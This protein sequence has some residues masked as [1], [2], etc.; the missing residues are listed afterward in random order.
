[1]VSTIPS[2][3]GNP[4]TEPIQGGERLKLPKG[5]IWFL[6]QHAQVTVLAK[7]FQFC[8]TP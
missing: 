8:L 7:P 5:S 6:C 4:R 2:Q 1:M 3:E